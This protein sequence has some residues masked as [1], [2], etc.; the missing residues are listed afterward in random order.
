MKAQTKH[1]KAKKII[2]KVPLTDPKYDGYITGLVKGGGKHMV[3]SSETSQLEGFT[4]FKQRM[5]EFNFVTCLTEE[6]VKLTKHTTFWTQ[7][8]MAV[9]GQNGKDLALDVDLFALTH[10]FS[11]KRGPADPSVFYGKGKKTH[12]KNRIDAFLN[13]EHLQVLE[14]ETTPSEIHRKHVNGRPMT[15][16]LVDGVPQIIH[17]S[18]DD[19]IDTRFL[20]GMDPLSVPLKEFFAYDEGAGEFKQDEWM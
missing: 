20:W 12:V 9:T 19:L 1:P 14:V 13:Q 17:K 15:F 4:L 18:G 3:D 2:I 16:P 5:P 11:D 10:M 6:V 8:G 7:D